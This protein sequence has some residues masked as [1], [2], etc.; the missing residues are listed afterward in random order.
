MDKKLIENKLLELRLNAIAAYEDWAYDKSIKSTQN[1]ISGFG[2]NDILMK[3]DAMQHMI[4]MLENEKATHGAISDFGRSKLKRK[5]EKEDNDEIVT[6]NIL[7]KFG[8]SHCIIEDNELKTAIDGVQCN[9][10]RKIKESKDPMSIALLEKIKILEK[11]MRDNNITESFRCKSERVD[12]EQIATMLEEANSIE[13]D[14][15]AD[16]HKILSQI[17]KIKNENLFDFCDRKPHQ[18]LMCPYYY[19]DFM[20]FSEMMKNREKMGGND[21]CG[22]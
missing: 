2:E 22:N 10:E 5:E 16:R 11:F 18:C 7:N 19:K 1:K 8:R 4:N 13:L 3:P 20:E 15:E 6:N 21:E 14:D 9:L 12:D 17:K